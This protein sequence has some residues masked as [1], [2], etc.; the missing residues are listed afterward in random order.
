MQKYFQNQIR[1]IE[2]MLEQKLP[3]AGTAP[4]PLHAAMRYSIFSGGKRLRPLLCLAAAAAAG[5][6]ASLLPGAA[7][8]HCMP[9][10]PSSMTICRPWTTTGY[11]GKPT[12]FTWRTGKPMPYWPVTPC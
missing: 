10:L 1:R 3:P 2:N 7:W 6:T 9:T 4:Q 5:M 8:K 11:A 12:P